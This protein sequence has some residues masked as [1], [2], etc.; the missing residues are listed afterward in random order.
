VV[1][2]L[3]R[4]QVSAT[5]AGIRAGSAPESRL[6]VNYQQP[7]VS[8]S[9]GRLLMLAVTTLARRPYPL[10]GEPRRSAWTPA[11][12]RRLLAG[13]DFTVTSDDDLL[14]LAQR[15][16]IE[17]RHRRSLRAGRVLVADLD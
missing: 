15:L 14:S 17:V 3:T 4:A 7:S 13:H 12:M 11:A 16:P 9:V 6:I 10:A 5:V 8:A 2:Y 1:P